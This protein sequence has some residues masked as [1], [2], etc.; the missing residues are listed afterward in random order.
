M[1]PKGWKKGGDSATPK[2]AAPTP[3][4][5]TTKTTQVEKGSSAP[6]VEQS[7][8]TVRTDEHIARKAVEKP[9]TLEKSSD[10]EK[11]SA[12]VLI[13]SWTENGK[14]YTKQYTCASLEVNE[15]ISKTFMKSG[16]KT[17]VDISVEAQVIE[18]L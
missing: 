8:V 12:A 9:S 2:V 10:K 18:V 14:R 7:S 16:T 17:T 4:V 6:S 11:D 15:S 1:P 3:H 13:V 5:E